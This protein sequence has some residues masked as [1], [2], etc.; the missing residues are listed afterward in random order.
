MRMH[1]PTLIAGIGVLAVVALAGCGST[2]KE[3]TSPTA[4]AGQSGAQVEVGNTI[5]YGSFGTTA[6]LDCA[7]GK[8]LNVGGS[9]NTLT[10]KGS[11]SSV[12]IGGADNK[13]TFEKVDKELSVV[14]L[15]NTVTYKGG[16]PKVNNLGSGNTINKG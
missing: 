7:D 13:I 3:G 14:G 16:E 1:S 5:N 10:V 9:N 15:N 11:C 12:N 8:S 4:T 2:S 6:D